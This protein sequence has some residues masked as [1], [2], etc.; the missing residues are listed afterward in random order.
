MQKSKYFIILV[1]IVLLS[2]FFLNVDPNG[3]AFKDYQNHLVVINDFKKNFFDTLFNYDKYA[4]RHSPVLYGILSFFYSLE[5]PDKFIRLFFLHIGIFLPFIFYKCLK[6]KFPSSNKDKLVLFSCLILFS[7]SFWSLTIWPDSRIF[8][9]ILFCIS[10]FYFLKFKENQNLNNSTKCILY[11]SA[12]SYLSPNFA[13]FSIFYFYHFFKKFKISKEILIIIVLNFI[14]SVPAFLYL[15]SLDSIFLIKSAV[16]SNEIQASDFLNISN[17][18]LIISSIIFFYSIP[19]LLAKSFEIEKPKLNIIILSLLV[20][21][22]FS[23]NFNY[24]YLFTGGGIFFKLS[25]FIT[26]NNYLFFVICFFSILFLLSLIKLNFENFIIIFLL[27]IS[28]PQYTV[29]H[30]YYDP[31]ILILFSLL[32]NIKINQKKLFNFNSLIIF[33]IHI[34]SFLILNFIK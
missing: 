6:L 8:G 13:V 19:F 30:K 31:L 20:L 29:Y 12:A 27:I 26:N 5:I 24:N 4:T 17:K 21:I 25:H 34:G 18:I 10:I 1:Y 3:G 16:P 22:L 7:P 32:F 33:Y 9:L 28:N 14:L 11:Y 2:A 15:F 23:Y